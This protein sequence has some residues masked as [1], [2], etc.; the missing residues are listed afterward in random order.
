[1]TTDRG[2][3]KEDV[4]HKY[5]GLLLSHKKERKR[6]SK[7]K[8]K[9]Q[10]ANWKLKFRGPERVEVAGDVQASSVCGKG[11]DALVRATGSQRETLVAWWG[12]AGS[13][14][15]PSVCPLSSAGPYCC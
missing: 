4:V 6:Q 14:C 5:N 8:K 11:H 15:G 13:S 2:V 1:M 9:K 3:D 12:L 7:K 10:Q